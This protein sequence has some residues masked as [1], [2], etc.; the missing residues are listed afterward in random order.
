MHIYSYWLLA[1]TQEIRGSIPELS[2]NPPLALPSS[3]TRFFPHLHLPH[4]VLGKVKSY[5][6]HEKDKHYRGSIGYLG[7]LLSEQDKINLLNFSLVIFLYFLLFSPNL[8]SYIFLFSIL[9][10]QYLVLFL[11]YTSVATLKC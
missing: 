9:Q 10:E 7:S 6:K 2:V 1:S 5:I 8:A 11:F 4:H 3:F